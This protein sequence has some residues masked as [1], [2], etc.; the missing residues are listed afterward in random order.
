MNRKTAIKRLA[1]LGAG[2]LLIYTGYRGY[3]IYREPPL[4]RLDQYEAVINEIAGVIIPATYTPGAKEANV[5]GFIIRMVKDCT[6]RPSQNNF[7]DGIEDLVSYSHS[8]YDK[9]FEKCSPDEQVAILTRFERNGKPFDGIA[10]KIEKRVKG[11]SF[12]MTL[13]KYTVL[14]YG[15][16]KIGCTEG[17]AYD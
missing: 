12:F 2:G 16:S 3:R 4:G 15:S 11:E 14:G 13:K 6:P 17:F 1:L 9:P 7:I 5:G 10:G 8:R